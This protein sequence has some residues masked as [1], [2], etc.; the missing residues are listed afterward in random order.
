LSPI[1][2]FRR[3]FIHKLW[4]IQSVSHHLIVCRIFLSSFTLCTTYSF[5]AWSVQLIFS[6][7]MTLRKLRDN[8][9]LNRKY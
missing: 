7:R 1:T 6:I 3:Q 9:D 4:L 2:C 8:G 5:I